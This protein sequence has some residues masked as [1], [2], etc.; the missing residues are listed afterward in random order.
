MSINI[1]TDVL[2][3]T[4]E[5]TTTSPKVDMQ[6]P[7]MFNVVLYND[8]TTSVDFVVLILMTIFHKDFE[9]ASDLTMHIHEHGKGI[10]GT[11]SH[12]VAHQKKDE[13]THV[14]RMNKMQLKCEVEVS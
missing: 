9:D 10:A 12:E 8:D 14:S 6:P 7:S 11:Y 5:V 4:K 1:D 13:T 2:T 3:K